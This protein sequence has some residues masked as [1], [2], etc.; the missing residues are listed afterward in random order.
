[1]RHDLDSN[2]QVFFVIGAKNKLVEARLCLQKGGE[3]DLNVQKQLQGNHYFVTEL[4]VLVADQ[5]L[6]F[7][8]AIRQLELV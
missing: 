5:L 7:A 3:I 4:L 8:G 2:S 6:E 1:M